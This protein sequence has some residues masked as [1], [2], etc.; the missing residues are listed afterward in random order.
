MGKRGKIGKSRTGRKEKVEEGEETAFH[1]LTSPTLSNETSRLGN[2]IIC[3][4]FSE[5]H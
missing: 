2:I 5:H 1:L 4:I 3:T